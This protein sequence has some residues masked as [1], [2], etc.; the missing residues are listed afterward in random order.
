MVKHGW[1]IT[2]DMIDGDAIGVE[3]LMLSTKEIR[4]DLCFGLS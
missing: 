3:G 2:K 4:E 1:V